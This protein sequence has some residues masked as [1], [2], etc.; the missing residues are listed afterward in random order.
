VCSLACSQ[1]KKTRRKAWLK[2]E[3]AQLEAFANNPRQGNAQRLV[4]LPLRKFEFG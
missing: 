3:K 2:G 1:G 4:A